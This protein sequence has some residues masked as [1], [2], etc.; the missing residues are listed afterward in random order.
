MNK[1]PMIISIQAEAEEAAVAEPT[2]SEAYSEGEN[3]G[4]DE[5]P[6]RREESARNAT[7]EQEED[8]ARET[9]AEEKI[10]IRRSPTMAEALDGTEIP[11]EIVDAIPENLR[12]FSKNGIAAALG[13]LGLSEADLQNE[14]IANIVEMQLEAEEAD[15][16]KDDDPE[17]EQAEKKDATKPEQQAM[18]L[19]KSLE[20]LANSP[21]GPAKIK[22]LNEH[23]AAV[24]ERSKLSNEPVMLDIFAKGLAATLQ[25]PPE[26]MPQLRETVEMLGYAG[27]A[28][29]E[30]AMP[31]MLPDLINSYMRQNFEPIL[32]HFVPG[33]SEAFNSAQ[34]DRCWNEIRSENDNFADLP[35]FES[36]E[37]VELRG[38]IRAAQPWIDS[39]DPDPKMTPL[40]ALKAKAGLFARLAVGERV[41]QKKIQQTIS[42]ALVTGRRSAEKSTR[43][44]STQRM[45]GRGRTAGSIGDLKERS[46]L[47]EAFNA[48]HGRDKDGI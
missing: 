4:L 5:T 28:L 6:R 41:D 18:P 11:E 39:W 7:L 33:I 37:F 40:Q 12:R 16:P 26:A 8:S 35:D 20:E 13:V 29:I 43:R 31:R 2:L 3:L 32:N 9:D 23:V 34:A 45:L 21:D 15:N 19:P 17:V 14:Q 38:K 48:Q 1:E 27:Q 24:Y 30:S 47:M 36:K 42:D 46:G 25:T 10:K 44:V 22:E